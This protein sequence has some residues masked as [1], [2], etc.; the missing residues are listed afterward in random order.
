MSSSFS[1]IFTLPDDGFLKKS[2]HVAMR[3]IN[4]VCEYHTH[5]DTD[6]TAYTDA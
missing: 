4:K 3:R 6:Q 2:K 1:G 5:P